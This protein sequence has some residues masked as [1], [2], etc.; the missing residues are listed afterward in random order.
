[1]AT[2]A[3]QLGTFVRTDAVMSLLCALVSHPT[4]FSRQGFC[5]PGRP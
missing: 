1:M 4:P 2:C 5:S 3:E